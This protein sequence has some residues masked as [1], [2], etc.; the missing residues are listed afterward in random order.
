[1]S[2]WFNMESLKGLTEK[3]NA[4][5]FK[6]FTDKVQSALPKIDDSLIEKLTLTSPELAEER[7]KID[8]EERAK[9]ASRNSFAGLLPWETRDPERDILVDECREAI[10]KLSRDR[11]T[12]SGPYAMP[13]PK[14]H[15]EGNGPDSES[16]I[17]NEPSKESKEK[18]EK[19]EPLPPRL[20]D[21]NL[22]AHVGL[23][24]RLLKEDPNLVKMQMSLSGT[25]V[26]LITCLDKLLLGFLIYHFVQ[27]PEA[28]A[29]EPF[30]ETI[31][32]IALL[33]GMRLVL[34]STKYGL[35][36]RQCL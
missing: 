24:E 27:Q 3:V 8:S 28:S 19:L 26:W 2:S 1:M 14:N 32:F 11:S 36:I 9:E 4:E 31:S 15:V 13:P 6:E 35:M 20:E 21:F 29:N 10:L 33:H 16:Q 25:H 22:D 5:S 18:L 17:R 7:H 30:G 12:F 34:V 23:I